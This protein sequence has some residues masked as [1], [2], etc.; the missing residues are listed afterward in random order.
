L[1]AKSHSNLVYGILQNIRGNLKERGDGITAAVVTMATL[2]G[3]HASIGT[4]ISGVFSSVFEAVG[5]KDGNKLDRDVATHSLY[6]TGNKEAELQVMTGC[7]HLFLANNFSKINEFLEKHIGELHQ[8]ISRKLVD[9][10]CT[11]VNSIISNSR[12]A[13]CETIARTVGML[14]ADMA[15]FEAKYKSTSDKTVSGRLIKA[16]FSTFNSGLEAL[17][18]QQ[19]AWRVSSGKLRDDLG[20]QLADTIVPVYRD[21]YAKYSIVSFTKRHLDQYI[22]FTAEDAQLILERFFGGKHG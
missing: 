17:L 21:F 9:S 11:E 4:G 3:H 16:K 12:A 10:Y 22:R 15:Q 7:P 1:E 14:A 8:C 20:R 2:S 6:E 19:G 13:F 5:I 18:A